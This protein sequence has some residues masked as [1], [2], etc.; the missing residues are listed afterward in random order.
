M[1]TIK[2]KTDEEFDALLSGLSERLGITRSAVIR[3][4]VGHFERTVAR[5]EWA[6]RIREAS[7]KTRDE[8]FRTSMDFDAAN[9]DG[10]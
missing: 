10:L 2:L 7:L 4:A 9:A 8:S 5:E 3:K 6:E 1:K